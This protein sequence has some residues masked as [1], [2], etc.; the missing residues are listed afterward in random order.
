MSSDDGTAPTAQV[1]KGAWSAEE[2]ELLLRAIEANGTRKWSVLASHLPGRTGKQC[3]E[4]WHN[5]LNPDISKSPWTEEEDRIIIREYAKFGARWADI[6]AVL[7][8][9]TDN[10]VKNRWNCSMRRKVEQLVAEDVA[11]GAVAPEGPEAAGA[12]LPLLLDEERIA[13]AV[14]RVRKSAPHARK[15]V[16]A[17]GAGAGAGGAKKRN[18][19]AIKLQLQ[20]QSSVAS[21]STAATVES[22]A[23]PTH[24]P[25]FCRA[26]RC[27]K[28]CA[29]A[30]SPSRR[31]LVFFSP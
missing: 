15:R 1:V 7:T 18:V 29:P 10:A 30:A 13:R 23:S 6:A 14:A 21:D 9:R 4:R 2:D 11:A 26:S 24:Q 8:G 20:S 5:Q 22:M 16:P 12:S 17:G 19:A 28:L 31:F 3:R 27:L 25:C